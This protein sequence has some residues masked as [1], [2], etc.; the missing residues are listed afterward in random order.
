VKVTELRR[1]LEKLEQEGNG[2]CQVEV[3]PAPP[4]LEV[5]ESGD[6]SGAV[7]DFAAEDY[8]VTE[9]IISSWQQGNAITLHFV[10]VE[11]VGAPPSSAAP[12]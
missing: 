7:F 5:I 9:I 10:P 4:P 11:P 1:R 8:G 2:Q 12:A 6:L 3:A